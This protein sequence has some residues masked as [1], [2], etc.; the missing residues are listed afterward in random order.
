MRIAVLHPSYEGSQAPYADLDPD[1][2]PQEYDATHEWTHLRIRKSTAVAQVI[3]AA[4]A[5]YDV[6]LNLC[7]GAWDEDRAGIEVPEAL[8]RLGVAFTGA[9]ARFYEPSR[10]AMKMAAHSVGVKVPPFVTVRGTEDS[11]DL[12]L[13]KLR[14]PMIVK[15]PNSYASIGMTAA[16]RV[17]TAEE[18]RTQVRQNA[19]KFGSA[20]V[21]EF[22]EGREY[23][24]LVTEPMKGHDM[25]W[26]LAPAEFVFP[27]GETFSHFDVK[28]NSEMDS[29]LV[30]D[31][32][33]AKRLRE[34]ASLVFAALGGTGYGRCDFRVDA[35]G[36]I[37]LLEINPNCE[38]FSPKDRYSAA[39]VILDH[40]P[41][42]HR[43]FLAHLIDCALRHQAR[44]K[45]AWDVDFSADRGFEMVAARDLAVGE[46]AV[47]YEE[48]TQRL[49]S[50]SFAERTWKGTKRDWFNRY[51]WP[52]GHQTLAVWSENPE[53]WRPINHSCDPNTWLMGLDLIARK[54]V[55]QGEALTVDYATFCG[56]TMT[57]FPCSC[58]VDVCRRMVRGDDYLRPELRA[59][60]GEHVSD[61]V[62]ASVP[63]GLL[64]VIPNGGGL[65]LISNASWKA[66]DVVSHLFWAKSI[67]VPSRYTI[68]RSE[69]LHAE[70]M[71]FELRYANHSCAPNL[72]FDVDA[73]V[74]RAVRD[75]APK[76][77]LTFFYPSTEWSMAD[78]FP[79][80]CGAPTCVGRVS[81]AV[82]LSDEVLAQYTLSDYV[83]MKQRERA[84]ETA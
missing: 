4:R 50:Q 84:R 68:Q 19:E 78:P 52:L 21:E 11:T 44:E 16:S 76:E 2:V 75:I 49:V 12:I 20:L 60:Y 24:V 38:V 48:Q 46:I 40:E 71:P 66:G 72:F 29:V 37:Y 30:K 17:T 14:F 27:E 67:P 7:D 35:S 70:P 47:R 34:A 65:S 9:R 28:W 69:R 79:C 82:S 39:N 56:P 5:G 22:I 45:R 59:R 8:E 64:D 62:S 33:L 25:P 58:G 32:M 6:F 26:A 43:A 41:G 1:A 42:G 13:T 74:V 31:F 18:L 61:F 3:E 23:T 63:Q 83:G 80:A 51:A 53:E 57:S 81:G 54:S 15:H 36:D 73:G 10:T 55:K 77:H